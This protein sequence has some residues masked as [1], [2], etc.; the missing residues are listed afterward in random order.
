MASYRA[1]AAVTE[2]LRRRLSTSI[3][4]EL[5]DARVVAGRPD[6]GLG[7]DTGAVSVFLFGVTPRTGAIGNDLPARGPGGRPPHAPSMAL[8]L[9]Y[10]LSFTGEEQSLVSQRM[11][12]LALAS[13]QAAP[14]LSDAEL[15]AAA[16]E[17]L[18]EAMELAQGPERVRLSITPQS[19]EDMSRLWSMVSHHPYQLSV[20]CTAGVVFIESG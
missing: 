13:L 17:G 10:L 3:R 5:P 9:H 14:V 8:D 12:G 7:R 1:I 4:A 16:A 18:P 20:V 2:V 6:E 11:L 15:G 19:S